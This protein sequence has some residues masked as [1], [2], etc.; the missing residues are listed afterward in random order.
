MTWQVLYLFVIVCVCVSM[1]DCVCLFVC[2]C[3]CVCAEQRAQT[4]LNNYAFLTLSLFNSFLI[5]LK[6][7]LKPVQEVELSMENMKVRCR[8]YQLIYAQTPCTLVFKI[9]L[10]AWLEYWTCC[11]ESVFFSKNSWKFATSPWPALGC[12]LMSQKLPANRGD[13]P[14]ALRWEPWISLAV[15]CEKKHNFARTPCI[16]IFKHRFF[17]VISAHKFEPCECEPFTV[18]IF[19]MYV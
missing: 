4:Y 2:V 1:C 7:L 19:P 11:A 17:A 13:C 5:M 14:L 10:Y 12:Y 3:E 8:R 16:F 18:D 9:W 6:E 15:N